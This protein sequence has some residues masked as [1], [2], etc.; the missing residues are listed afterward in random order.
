[1]VL[2]LYHRLPPRCKAKMQRTRKSDPAAAAGAV[3]V[4]YVFEVGEPG[5][6]S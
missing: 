5:M 3:G 2:S 4:L 1:M 6:R